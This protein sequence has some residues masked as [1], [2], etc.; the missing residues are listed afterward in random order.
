M[1]CKVF[2]SFEYKNSIYFLIYKIILIFFQSGLHTYI[3]KV[4]SLSLIAQ[5]RPIFR[6]VPGLPDTFILHHHTAKIWAFFVFL[7]AVPDG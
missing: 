7:V 5:I 2:V 6:A 1:V 4:F 3:Y